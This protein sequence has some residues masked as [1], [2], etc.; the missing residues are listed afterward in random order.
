M[1]KE[2]VRADAD[3]MKEVLAELRNRYVHLTS[4]TCKMHKH[5]LMLASCHAAHCVCACFC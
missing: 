4:K 2:F 3:T 5:V 1:N